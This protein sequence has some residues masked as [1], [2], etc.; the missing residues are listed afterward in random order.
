[1][2][3]LHQ[4]HYHTL[5]IPRSAG[6]SVQTRA[7]EVLQVAARYPLPYARSRGGNTSL[8]RRRH[9][10]R[11]QHC[12]VRGEPQDLLLQDRERTRHTRLVL[13]WNCC[14]AHKTQQ[15]AHRGVQRPNEAQQEQLRQLCARIRKGSEDRKMYPDADC[16]LY[17]IK[18]NLN[19]MC[20]SNLPIVTELPFKSVDEYVGAHFS[21]L[22]SDVFSQAVASVRWRLGLSADENDMNIESYKYATKAVSGV[23][24]LGETLGDRG[25]WI[26][27]KFLKSH[28]FNPLRQLES[29]SLVMIVGTTD[30]EKAAAEQKM[31][32]AT[33]PFSDAATASKGIAIVEV[34]EGDPQAMIR[35]LRE[36]HA[37]GLS[38][39]ESF[40]FET[41]VFLH[42]V[43]PVLEALDLLRKQPKLPFNNTLLQGSCKSETK[44][45]PGYVPP[46]YKDAFENIVRRMLQRFT[47]EPGQAKALRW[48]PYRPVLLVQGPPGTGKSFIG[49]RLVE[50]IAEFRI[51]M[52]SG[53]LKNE[54]QAPEK[55][56]EEEHIETPGPIVVLTY[57]NH[58]LDEF[59]ID[60]INSGVWCGDLRNPS[61]CACKSSGPSK[62]CCEVCCDRQGHAKKLVRIGARSTSPKLAN[63]NLATLMKIKSDHRGKL[64]S[65][66]K[67]AERLAAVLRRLDA[68]DLDADMVRD[69]LD[70]SQAD[71]FTTDGENLLQAWKEWLP[72]G[73]IV[74]PVAE[75]QEITDL[76]KHIL[77]IGLDP[78]EVDNAF[79]KER[80]L[81]E[82]IRKE[83]IEA[84]EKAFLEEMDCGSES[85]MQT[86]RLDGKSFTTVDEDFLRNLRAKRAFHSS[87]APSEP[88]T[89]AKR[90][91]A[92]ED[93]DDSDDIPQEMRTGRLIPPE[94]ASTTDL[95]SL[96]DDQRLELAAYWIAKARER[97]TEKF[98]H[99]KREFDGMLVLDQ[100]AFDEARLEALKKADIIGLTTTGAAMNQSI[101]RAVKPSVLMVEEAAE[102]L[103]GQILSCFVDTV[104]QIILIGDHK[105]LM[106]G[107]ECQ[108]YTVYNKFD[109]SLFQRLIENC[110]VPCVMLTEQRRMKP[111]IADIVRPIYKTL[112]DFHT[113]ATRTMH[114]GGKEVL[115]M[116]HLPPVT[117]WTHTVMEQQADVGLSIM[118]VQEA[119]MVAFLCKYLV[120]SKGLRPS[121]LTVLTPYLGQTRVLTSKLRSEGI[122]NVKVLTVDRF[123][124]DENDIIIVS[125]TR[126]QNLTSF[127]RLENRMCVAC[128][129]ARFGFFMIGSSKLLEKSPHWK[130]T[131]GIIESQATEEYKTVT[132]TLRLAELGSDPPRFS[133]FDSEL[134]E[135]P[136]P[137]VSATWEQDHTIKVPER[138]EE[139]E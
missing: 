6:V 70:S 111:A 101:L 23:E 42:G 103:E 61:K 60:C 116:P 128:S 18:S 57:K 92:E 59:L 51:R 127:M 87:F 10:A 110:K 88:P 106:P 98:N 138:E 20:P 99:I 126:T 136:D 75:A 91:A 85:T 16:F 104:K 125:L 89:I 65:L 123:Q 69:F 56:D 58:S 97:V 134:T 54:Y 115:G 112:T 31:W 79:L 25:L 7:V 83:Y 67:E 120:G 26:A 48:L 17:H 11:A 36:N 135:F 64:K 27:L 24:V 139:S 66:R 96:G 15:S 2:V 76:G 109:T 117:F 68:L 72:E 119:K 78:D 8:R 37:R 55:P 122:E 94:C 40:L 28:D 9:R 124:G 73:N 62:Y 34:V 132:P 74:T 84:R 49:C 80:L 82:N 53:E 1:M 133:N 41:R 105:Q 44:R 33:I 29:G 113:L 46:C 39:T 121:Q 3:R 129:R 118:N 52:L 86:I 90:E 14:L 47:Y 81:T 100:Y 102:I 114:F 63:Y 71:K 22:K 50:C 43:K 107:T 38:Q 30:M 131:L 5:R 19:P 35:C 130:R 95:W 12:G 13:R 93:G 77:G 4:Q 137:N 21:L 45:L 108:E 32:W